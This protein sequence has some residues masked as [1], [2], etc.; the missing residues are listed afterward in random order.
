MI[1]AILLSIAGMF[2]L[3]ASDTLPPCEDAGED[4]ACVTFDQT[5]PEGPAQWIITDTQGSYRYDTHPCATLAIQPCL[6]AVDGGW[7]LVSDG[8]L[9]DAALGG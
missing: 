9:R 8:S 1:I 7:V 6:I 2:G 3:H 4:A 5:T